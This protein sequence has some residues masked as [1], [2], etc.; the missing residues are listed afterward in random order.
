M[1]NQIGCEAIS[2]T[3]DSPQPTVDLDL[4][5]L[6]L[7]GTGLFAGTPNEDLVR[8]LRNLNFKTTN[9]LLCS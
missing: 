5:D 4:Y 8:Y 3:A 7:V 1:A 9:C 2:L 6:V